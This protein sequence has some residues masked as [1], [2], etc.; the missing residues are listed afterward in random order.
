MSAVPVV[1]QNGS[2]GRW[3]KPLAQ[4]RILG[5]DGVRRA[6]K[7]KTP[8]LGGGVG[9]AVPLSVTRRR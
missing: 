2:D 4:D 7:T 6:R 8:P 5:G 1:R 9:S 3:V